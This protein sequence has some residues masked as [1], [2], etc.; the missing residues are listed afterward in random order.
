M[1]LPED[2]IIMHRLHFELTVIRCS[3]LFVLCALPFALARGQ[4]VT[5]TLSGTVE[6]Q[7]GALVPNATVTAINSGTKLTRD[8]TTDPSGAYAFPLLPPGAYTIR[9]QAQGFAT[10]ETGNVVLNVGDQK[11]LRIQLR[12]GAISEMV[13]VDSQAPLIN[14]SPAVGT[15]V[16]RQFV[17]N[18]PLNGR[19]FQSLITLTPGIVLTPATGSESGQFSVNGQRANANYFTVDGVSANVAQ[20]Y[21]TG[22]AFGQ[23]SA[24]A[25]P[26]LAATGGT[27]SLVSIDALEEFKLLTSTY[28]PEY[29]RQPGGQVALLTRS[30]TRSFHGSIFDYLRN[31]KLDATDFFV[32]A[33][34]LKKAPLRQNIFGGTLSGPLFLP[35]FG[36]GGPA[37]INRRDRTFFF[38]S[39]EGHRLLLPKFALTDVPSLSARQDP[40]A[41]PAIRQLLNAYPLPTGPERPNR[42]ADFAAS[43]SDPSSVDATSIRID[44]AIG[45]RLNV[46]GRYSHSP[47]QS[48]TRLGTGGN[49]VNTI[50]RITNKTQ[51]LTLGATSVLSGQ[52]TNELRG[53]WT[54]VR[55]A[56]LFS[57]DNFGSAVPPDRSFFINPAFD[58][59]LSGASFTITGGSFTQLRIGA[60]ADNLQRQINVVDN[61]SWV[62][63]AHQLKFGVDYRRLTPLLGASQYSQQL[64]FN[65]IAGVLSGRTSSAAILSLGEARE[66]LYTNFSAFAQDVWKLNERLTLTYGLRWE[67][68]PPPTELNGNHPAV[69]AGQENP[70]TMSLAP[71]GTKL[72][73]TTY[74]NFAPRVGVAYQIS[75][76]QGQE[77][78]L[79]G[80]FGIF[81]DLGSDTAA[82]ALGNVFP[83]IATK[84]LS[85]AN[86][87]FFPPT[88]TQAA[89]ASPGRSLPATTEVI[90]IDPNLKLPRTYQFSF[91]VERSL[92]VNQTFSATYVGSLG[93]KLLRQNSYT[94]TG[95][96]NANFQIV[97]FTRNLAESNYHALQL[98][99]QRR[100]SRGLQLQSS[101]TWSHSID[102]SSND[103]GR[104][105]SFPLGITTKTDRGN[106]DFDTR[107]SFLLAGTYN[108]P[109]PEWGPVA[110]AIISGWSIDALYSGRSAPPF[111]VRYFFSNTLLST[112]IARPDLVTSV[113]VYLEDPAAPGGRRLNPAAFLIPPASQ[114]RQ[115][116]LGRNILRGFPL[117]QLDFSIRRG[118]RI[119][120]RLGLQFKA[121]LFN[122]LNHP[123]FASPFP[124]LGQNNFGVSPSMLN[125]SLGTGGVNG[126]LNPLYQVGGPR[127]V[128]LSLKVEF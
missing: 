70:A 125:R 6:D 1:L 119:H 113:P 48:E 33:N 41:S 42:F 94:G 98:Q 67:L 52:L 118:F 107:H 50:N 106:S 128:Q 71:F 99:F 117:S 23:T 12:A 68:N 108:V 80:G 54:R 56:S 122:A 91:A 2:S 93:R 90:A 97:T 16:D 74:N 55:A 11:A 17:A 115:G 127:S 24:G 57:M 58:S 64:A 34:R 81:Y 14:E 37:F 28:A 9:I 112:I 86:L 120:E 110:N 13:R 95:L 4:S 79:R 44:H 59:P 124:L 7:N 82:V 26:A 109:A 84:F 30:G 46:F 66:P 51:T 31:E 43:Y 101:Y 45:S 116:S 100:L 35:R 20:T 22:T 75:Q 61:L 18:L 88:V 49:T 85:G 89:P 53:N 5:A 104:L 60:L 105:D 102:S 63:R 62:Q 103:S 114:A 8:T 27:S 15:V 83:F 39:Y 10:V 36:E 87:P 78:M 65:G 77:T 40:N 76:S 111:N 72:Y 96:S 92:G 38:F 121:E 3:L 32:K 47:S 25:L 21:L 29:G 123:N 19:S 73:K 69:V 126:G